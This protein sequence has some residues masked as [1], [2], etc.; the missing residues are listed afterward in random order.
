VRGIQIP[1]PKFGNPVG[2]IPDNLVAMLYDEARS[3]MGVGAFTASIL[4]CRKLLMNVA[5]SIGAKEGLSFISYVK[6]LS[7]GGYVPP[8]SDVWLDHI[9]DK[10][11]E[12]NHKIEIS[13]KVDAEELL[14]FTEMLL[15]FVFELPAKIKQK[16]RKT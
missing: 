4:C 14:N 1:S 3:C 8:G 9:R 15:R 13:N 12:A 7:D 16:T 11:N 5:V 2:G 6:F 10:G